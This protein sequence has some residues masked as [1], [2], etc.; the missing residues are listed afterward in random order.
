M[1]C[2]H[3]TNFGS[4]GIETSLVLFKALRKRAMINFLN[5]M[6]TYD[7]HCAVLYCTFL[8]NISH[9]YITLMLWPSTMFLK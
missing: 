5:R 2:G 4:H 7:I 3:M 1:I 9:L 8:Q 6:V